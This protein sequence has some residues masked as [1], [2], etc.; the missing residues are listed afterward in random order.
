M[1]KRRR[2]ADRSS[3]DRSRW[4]RQTS[5][6]VS[7]G[8]KDIRVGGSR[9]TGSRAYELER[10][11]EVVSKE[12]VVPGTGIVES[13]LDGAAVDDDM[14][15]DKLRGELL[16]SVDGKLHHS[17]G[18]GSSSGDCTAP[19]TRHVTVDESS[20]SSQADVAQSAT[21]TTTT[22]SRTTTDESVDTDARAADSLD[23]SVGG[24]DPMILDAA[25]AVVNSVQRK[26]KEREGDTTDRPPSSLKKRK[27]RVMILREDGRLQDS[28]VLLDP[29]PHH[30]IPSSLLRR[31]SGQV[32]RNS[33]PLSSPG[34]SLPSSPV[35]VLRSTP[36]SP[37]KHSNTCAVLPSPHAVSPASRSHPASPSSSMRGGS[38]TRSVSPSTSSS[39]AIVADPKTCFT[40][41]DESTKQPPASSFSSSSYFSALSSSDPIRV[42]EQPTQ[43]TAPSQPPVI[44]KK[45]SRRKAEYQEIVEEEVSAMTVFTSPPQ[46]PTAL[47]AAKRS[48]SD[49]TDNLLDGLLACGKAG[50][51]GPKVTGKSTVNEHRNASNI[52]HSN[53]KYKEKKPGQEKDPRQEKKPEQHRAKAGTTP[54]VPKKEDPRLGL[55]VED[56]PLVPLQFGTYVNAT[57]RQQGLHALLRQMLQKRDSRAEAIALAVRELSRPCY[58]ASLTCL[59]GD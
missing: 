16:R 25:N 36:S 31:H 58:T 23:C 19:L 13:N 49:F 17:G 28:E 41:S 1:R 18:L 53:A 48:K 29:P 9:D 8:D 27:S 20:L 45:G 2:L 34:S 39:P 55:S 37:A 35:R 12:S 6:D 46:P 56:Y 43:S 3:H 4:Q 24:R 50:R 7:D 59:R 51:N 32:R 26:R 15:I 54:A 5:L 44:L 52:T 38:M 22:T 33:S 57:I 10:V 11:S 47:D 42:I 30:G 21:T 40:S 14:D